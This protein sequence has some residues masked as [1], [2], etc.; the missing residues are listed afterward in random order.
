MVTPYTQQWNLTMEQQL[1]ADMVLSTGYVGSK[2]SHLFGSRNINAA[3][4]APGA[5][6]A[7]TQARRPYPLFGPIEDEHTIGYSQYHSLQ[8][9]LRRRM[10]RG[11]RC[12][13][14]IRFP[15]IPAI[16]QARA[17]VRWGLEIHLTRPSTTEF[18]LWMPPMCSRGPRWCSSL[19]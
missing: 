10:S 11:L 17:K 4:Y 6:V 2:S 16:R 19:C 3:I 7:N 13:P 8:I 12:R 18:F 1:P 14:R 15:R 5:T 9:L